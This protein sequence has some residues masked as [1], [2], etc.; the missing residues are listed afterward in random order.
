MCAA[1]TPQAPFK[2][3]SL[4]FH[5]AT[6]TWRITIGGQDRYLGK[7]PKIAR[8]RAHA[9]LA[10]Y[11]AEGPTEIPGASEIT[12]SELVGLYLTR[13]CAEYYKNSPEHVEWVRRILGAFADVYGAELA[14]TITPKRLKTY[15]DI[16][17]DGGFFRGKVKEAKLPCRKTINEK[18][19][20]I[21]R[22]FRWGVSEE[23]VKES[24]WRSLESVENLH[25][26]R[27]RAG[28]SR[29]VR[30]VLWEHVEA[31]LP[32]LSRPARGLVLLC[33]H[34]GCRI[35]E[36][37]P[38][39]AVDI[40][41]SGPV[42][43]YR[44]T[45]HKNQWRGAGF[46]RVIPFGPEAQKVIKEF[47]GIRG[48]HQPLFSPKDVYQE[49]QEKRSGD[50][51]R[52][53]QVHVPKTDRTLSEEYDSKV[54]THSIRRAVD[55][56][57]VKRKVQGLTEIPRWTI[58]QVRHSYATRVRRTYGLEQARI[59]LGHSDASVTLIYAEADQE[60]SRTIAAS[61]G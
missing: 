41:M 34:T 20:L 19:S 23:L 54:L 53:D 26:G 25:A 45:R 4:R 15:R 11:L 42:W 29:V 37:T 9:L 17:I 36:L 22:L 48:V 6:G 18:T 5:K 2:T 33:W 49:R 24:V 30:P 38:L 39:R 59:A 7:D 44:P 12:L 8:Q 58:H 10:D 57:N 32:Y 3:P 56:A 21:K 43:E 35:G 28:E 16:L 60:I 47:I 27:S 50:G 13:H 55:T 14:S 40:N 31:T 51:R 46:E 1:R 61:I 52:E